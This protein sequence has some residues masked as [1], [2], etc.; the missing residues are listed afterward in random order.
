MPRVIYLL[1]HGDAEDGDGDDAARR[2]TPKG[3]APGR[4]RRSRP[5]GARRRDRC[6]PDQPEGAG[7]RNRTARLR[8]A[9]DRARGRP[10]ELRGGALR[11]DRPRSRPGRRP[12][13]RPRARLLGRGRPPYRRQGEA[14]E[15]RP[16]D[17]R[18]G[19]CSRSCARPLAAIAAEGATMALRLCRFRRGGRGSAWSRKTGLPTSAV[20]TA[21]PPNPPRPRGGRLPS[22]RRAR[23][24]GAEHRRST[25]SGCSARPCRASTWR[26]PSTTRTTSPRAAWRRRRCRCSSTSRSAASPAPAPTSTCRR[27]PTS[28]TTRA[29]WRS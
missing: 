15:G 22:A 23:R 21:C 14:E 24:R 7:R 19:P 17:R 4:G 10:I 27:S 25:R 16:G 8:A 26:S 6:L 2:L 29:S 12:P 20:S 3:R 1:R 13:G 9:R 11:R 28:S 18:G 5:G